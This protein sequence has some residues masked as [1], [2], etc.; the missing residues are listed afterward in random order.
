MSRAPHNPPIE[1]IDVD[2]IVI[3]AS[4]R[5]IDE[6]MVRSL[7]DSMKV[8]GLRT[9]ITLWGNE[10]HLELVAGAHRLA[11][12][13]LLS[14]PE[15]DCFIM[16]SDSVSH[17]QAEMWEISENLHRAELTVLQRSEQVARWVVLAD[18][19]SQLATPLGGRQPKDEGIRKAARDLNIPKDAVHRSKKIAD[20]SPEAKAAAQ[21]TGLADNQSALLAAAKMPLSQQAEAI[22]GV[23]D[24]KLRAAT[25][26]ANAPKPKDWSDV[27]GDQMRRLMSAWNAASPNVKQWFRD[28]IG[29]SVMDGSSAA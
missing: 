19:V 3:P 13:K 10:F 22:R 23:A 26:R 18:K 9:P 5:P 6:G 16:E 21:E 12:A 2:S 11:A 17:E 28:Q 1:K 20:L 25:E 7:A 15:I 14:W 4:R 24:S 29:A 27:D 8:M